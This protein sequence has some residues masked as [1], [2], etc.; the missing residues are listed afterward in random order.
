MP[1]QPVVEIPTQVFKGLPKSRVKT[2]L[3]RLEITNLPADL[4][5]KVLFRLL[6]GIAYAHDLT[7]RVAKHVCAIAV[8]L[9][10]QSRR[11]CNEKARFFEAV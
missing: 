7:R 3:V 11:A 6:Q 9:S 10:M 5:A 1:S 4:L 2:S 8:T